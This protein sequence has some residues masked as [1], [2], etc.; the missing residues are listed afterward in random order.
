[1]ILIDNL[2]LFSFSSS[3]LYFYFENKFGHVLHLHPHPLHLH[4]NSP[5]LFNPLK[6]TWLSHV[7]PREVDINYLIHIFIHD[8]VFVF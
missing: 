2:F 4:H 8:T 5:T 3:V 6:R 7:T 1:M